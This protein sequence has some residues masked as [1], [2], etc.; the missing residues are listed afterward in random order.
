MRPSELLAELH[1]ANERV[2]RHLREHELRLQLILSSAFALLAEEEE[3]QKE[4][5]KDK[6]DEAAGDWT[7]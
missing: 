2:Q 3:L 5:Q 4:F 6:D 7:R 1:A